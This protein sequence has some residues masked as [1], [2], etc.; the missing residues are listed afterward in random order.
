MIAENGKTKNESGIEISYNMYLNTVLFAGD[1]VIIE[2]TEEKLRLLVYKL[3]Q[4]LMHLSW[5][6][7]S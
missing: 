6:E 1:Q 3:Y 2:D 7:L 4:L 5:V